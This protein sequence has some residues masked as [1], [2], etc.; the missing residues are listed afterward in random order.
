MTTQP[1]AGPPKPLPTPTQENAS[2][3]VRGAK[4]MSCGCEAAMPAMS[5]ISTLVICASRAIPV[6]PR[7]CRR[8]DAVRSMRMPSLNARPA[9]ANR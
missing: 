6:I 5:G 7:G 1:P 9:D 8:A 3:V 4:S 2:S